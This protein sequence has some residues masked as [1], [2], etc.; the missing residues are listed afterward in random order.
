MHSRSSFEQHL[1]RLD[2]LRSSFDFGG[3]AVRIVAGALREGGEAR[4][5]ANAKMHVFRFVFR[6]VLQ[7]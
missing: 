1:C 4:V 2:A 5:G 7:I 3:Q 6:V